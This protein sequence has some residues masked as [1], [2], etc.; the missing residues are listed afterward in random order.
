MSTYGLTVETRPVNPPGA[1][2]AFALSPLSHSSPDVLFKAYIEERGY[3]LGPSASLGQTK[4]IGELRR[5]LTQCRRPLA[6]PLLPR[7]VPSI[8]HV[9]GRP[10]IA[11]SLTV[12]VEE[13]L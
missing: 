4:L 1:N 7:R 8:N 5:P 3:L 13:R 11:D 6:S 2:I 12:I 9:R 10:S